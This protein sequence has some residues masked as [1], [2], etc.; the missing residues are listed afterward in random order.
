VAAL[1]DAPV[2]PGAPG[3]P[4]EPGEPL[5]RLRTATQRYGERTV[6]AIEALEVW[7]GEVLAIVGPSGAGKSTLLRLL[8]FLERPASG[9]LAFRGEAGEPTLAARRAVTMVFQRPALLGAS[10]AANVAYGLR[11]RGLGASPERV[12]AA[13]DEVRLAEFARAPARRLSAGEQ[14]RVALARA[15]V[16]EPEVLLLDEPTAN[17]DPYNV[18]VIEEAIRA[19]N[20][21]RATT[22]V[23]VTHNVFQA[24]RLATRAGL[25]LDGR[26]VAAA[27]AGEFFAD[28]GDPRVRAFVRGEMVY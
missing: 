25:L 8:A 14:Q 24:Q 20:A 28:A 6:L 16:L 21:R 22:V 11:V 2:G 4:G 15:L 3:T 7:P 18:G 19:R 27:P 17:L 10:V 26:L 13:L 9:T 1:S 23:L 12:A 5:Y